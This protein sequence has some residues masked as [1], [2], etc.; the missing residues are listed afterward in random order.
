MASRLG[1]RY[2]LVVHEDLSSCCRLRNLVS[3]QMNECART[4]SLIGGVL[5]KP[6]DFQSIRVC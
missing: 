1:N 3:W 6:E 2:S 5:R 4:L